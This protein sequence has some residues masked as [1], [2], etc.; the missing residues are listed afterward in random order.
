MLDV[1]ILL[2][3]DEVNESD[4]RIKCRDLAKATDVCAC[5]KKN[6]D[7]VSTIVCIDCKWWE[8]F[9]KADKTK[10]LEKGNMYLV[11]GH[12]VGRKVQHLGSLEA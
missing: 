12:P 11:C 9:A 6:Y 1:P 3:K 2:E 7:P 5:A 4:E 10:P 8:G